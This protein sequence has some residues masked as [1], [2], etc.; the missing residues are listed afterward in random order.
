MGLMGNGENAIRIQ[1]VA[2]A[3]EQTEIH[4]MRRLVFRATKGKSYM[5]TQELEPDADDTSLAKKSVYIIVFWDGSVIRDKIYKICDCFS[6]QRFDLP[7]LQEIPEQLES[8]KKQIE[9]S[10]N[11]YES[12][13]QQLREQLFDFNKIDESDED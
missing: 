13:K 9:D 8:L 4:R 11:V 10:K 12:T 3:V 7:D 1:H 6:G 2:G 5:Y